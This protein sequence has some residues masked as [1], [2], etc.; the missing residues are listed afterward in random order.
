MAIAVLLAIAGYLGKPE[1]IFQAADRAPVSQ[2]AV[3]DQDAK[4]PLEFV[5][6]L[7]SGTF[8]ATVSNP[9][10][11]VIYLQCQISPL[12]ADGELVTT[13]GYDALTEQGRPT[14]SPLYTNFQ[15]VTPRGSRRFG[16]DVQVGAPARR[17][18]G[19]CEPRR[20][21]ANARDELTPE[22]LRLLSPE[23]R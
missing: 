12:G 19:G 1:P 8:T 20:M 13:H 22:G 16:A 2:E 7:E 15:L 6:A 5:R 3:A 21:P 4:Y 17:W 11:W 14:R 10:K 23:S 18:E 9:T